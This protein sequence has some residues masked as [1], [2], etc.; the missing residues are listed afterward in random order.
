MISAAIKEA[1][2]PVIG[3][4]KS[5]R[6]LSGGCIAN[7]SCVDTDQGRFFLKWSNGKA[8]QTFEAEG[9]GLKALADARSSL[10]IPEVLAVLSGPPGYLL[11]EWVDQ[12]SQT[13][14]F[15]TGFGYALAELH[16]QTGDAFGFPSDNFIGSTPQLNTMHASWPAFFRSC[17]LAPQ[18]TLAQKAG[19]WH[20]DWD[21]WYDSLIQRLDDILPL[22]PPASLLH[23]D[24]WSGNFMVAAAGNAAL[25]DPAVYFGHNEA[26]LAMTALFGG[27][28]Q[29]FYDAYREVLPSDVDY[30][31]RREVY[32]LY[33]LIN[34][35]NLFGKSYAGGVERILKRYA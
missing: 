2:R 13:P 6:P 35:L 23:G 28:D 11:L 8:A 27:F 32:N 18:R 33:H 14:S 20:R 4:L 30:S 9:Q 1:L 25:I 16:Q 24:L 3:E 5:V 15:W 7:A 19:L 22:N 21:M 10:E 31:E 26:D 29:A 12:G 17:R 34:H